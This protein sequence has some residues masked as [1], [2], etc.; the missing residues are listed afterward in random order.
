MGIPN[1]VDSWGKEYEHDWVTWR[2]MAPKVLDE[3]TR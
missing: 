3:W 2:A 1:Y